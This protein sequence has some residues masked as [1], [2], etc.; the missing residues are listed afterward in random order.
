LADRPARHLPHLIID[1]RQRLAIADDQQRHAFFVLEADL[2]RS[3]HRQHAAARS[4]I[5]I[6][7]L[8]IGR[9]RRDGAKVR[10]HRDELGCRRGGDWD[11][12]SGGKRR[13]RISDH[14]NVMWP[15]D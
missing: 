8:E 14:R 6:D 2:A 1:H 13:D 12:K 7:L 9:H 11:G 4:A 3:L 5:G 10:L 15:K